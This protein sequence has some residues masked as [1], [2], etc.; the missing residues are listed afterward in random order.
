MKRRPERPRRS[1]GGRDVRLQTGDARP[2]RHMSH[3]CFPGPRPVLSPLRIGKMTSMYSGS[4]STPRQR[5]PIFSQAINV[6]PEPRNG[7]MT[8]SPR[9]VIS[10][11]A[12]SNIATGLTVGW[13]CSPSPAS[14]ARAPDKVQTFDLPRRLLPRL[15]LSMWVALPFLNNGRSSC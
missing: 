9:S 4:S 2:V 15:T 7:P 8:M 5:R 3:R 1:E 6:D 13:C 10:R 14:E 11:S 12:S